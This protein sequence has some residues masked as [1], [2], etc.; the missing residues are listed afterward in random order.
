[1]VVVLGKAI[2]RN[3]DW[4]V[5]NSTGLCE[6]GSKLFYGFAEVPRSAVLRTTRIYRRTAKSLCPA[7]RTE[8]VSNGRA[9]NRCTGQ[10]QRRV[11]GSAQRRPV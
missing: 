2:R 11:T 9:Q 7:I 6:C 5:G 1:M 4:V 8:E 3:H 10:K